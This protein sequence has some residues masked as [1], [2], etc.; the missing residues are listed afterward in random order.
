MS[1]KDAICVNDPNYAI[2]CKFLQK[3]AVL[4]NITTIDTITLQK[5]IE[6]TDEGRIEKKYCFCFYC[7][8][9]FF[10]ITKEKLFT[11]PT[12]LFD[13]LVKLLRKNKYT[14]HLERWERAVI[15]FCYTYSNQDAW[16]IERFGYKK[17]KCAVKLRVLKVDGFIK[18]YFLTSYKL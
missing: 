10:L 3:F 11:V 13:L 6:N 2:T 8:L 17:S 16:E 9:Y 5:Q 1:D 4:C 7:H 12:E 14:V 18:F 15:K